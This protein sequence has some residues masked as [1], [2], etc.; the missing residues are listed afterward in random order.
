M[1]SGTYFVRL[2]T[3]SGVEARKAMLVRQKSNQRL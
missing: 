2:E 3:E 1:P